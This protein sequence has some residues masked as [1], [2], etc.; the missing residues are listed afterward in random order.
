MNPITFKI[1]SNPFLFS[2]EMKLI[3]TLIVRCC[4]GAS[5][6]SV[7]LIL[8]GIFF[9]LDWRI[10]WPSCSCLKM[11]AFEQ[12][13]SPVKLYGPETLTFTN[14][15]GKILEWR[16]LFQAIKS[17]NGRESAFCWDWILWQLAANGAKQEHIDKVEESRGSWCFSIIWMRCHCQPY[18]SPR[19]CLRPTREPGQN[20]MATKSKKINRLKIKRLN[21]RI[22]VSLIAM[23]SPYKAK[24]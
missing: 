4:I 23:D 22:N 2:I 9:W 8:S 10:Y 20:W 19:H 11:K 3:G 16:M 1:I 13:V 6:E 15:F 17:P 12:Y 21:I 5:V 24:R 18:S 7:N 14:V